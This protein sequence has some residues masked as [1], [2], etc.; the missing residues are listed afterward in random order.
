MDAVRKNQET[1]LDG[2]LQGIM[3]AEFADDL[4]DERELKARKPTKFY[5]PFVLPRPDVA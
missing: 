1:V 2:W 3:G 5:Q 4:M